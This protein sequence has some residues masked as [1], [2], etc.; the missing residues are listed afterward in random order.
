M[1]PISTR[2]G[3]Q[4]FNALVSFCLQTRYRTAAMQPRYQSSLRQDDQ[5][6]VPDV[7]LLKTT[8]PAL[9][10]THGSLER[11]QYG[12]FVKFFRQASPYIEGHRGRTFVIAIPGEVV[13][14]QDVLDSLL[15]DIALLHGLGVRLT[16]VIG[17]RMQIN[18]AIRAEGVEPRYAKGYRVTDDVA[19]KAAIAAAGAARMIVEARLS[20]APTVTMMRRHAR[21]TVSGRESPASSVSRNQQAP[22]V[23]TVS[24][25]YVAAKRKGVVGGVDYQHTGS[26][27]FVQ[28]EAVKHQLMNGNVVLL[29]NLGYSATGEPL[30]CD[31]YS[32][33][34][35]AA[36]DLNAD[37][38]IVVAPPG[39]EA[40]IAV[41]ELPAWIPLHEAETMLMSVARNA[42]LGFERSGHVTSTEGI[43]MSAKETNSGPTHEDSTKD[44]T[45]SPIDTEMGYPSSEDEAAYRKAADELDFD[46]WYEL[47]LPMPLLAACMVCKAGVKRAH[48]IDAEIDGALLLELYSTDGIGSMISSDFYEGIRSATVSDVP[49]I[50]ILLQ[51]LVERGVLVHRSREQLAE[52]VKYFTV[53]E[54]ES[55]ILACAMV[56]PL[57]SN[58]DAENVAELGAF[59]VHPEYRGGGKG[60]TLLEY[61][62]D[63]AHSS[64][65]KRLI[66][67]TTRTAEWFEQ[68]GFKA[69]GP[70]HASPMVPINRRTAIDPSRNS[71]LYYKI[72]G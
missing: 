41:S 68:R 34:V 46:S 59:C 24:G 61:L 72:V 35:R 49:R 48:L 13:D 70:A 38:L 21:S 18:Q 20:K 67:L 27:R 33:A 65:V 17:A 6:V 57:G 15:Q 22:A 36:V 51:P 40:G 10:R 39:G 53:L 31:I 23:T 7:P 8:T 11:A 69:A 50:H 1:Q 44:R 19:L 3:Y 5:S 55:E 52:D 54:R 12:L 62:E 4:S 56:R 66:L 42:S 71:Q 58:D 47:G 29:S 60:D 45:V 64:G 63:K 28:A 25:N 14:R 32:V 2:A 30:N 26:V 16:V 37:K 43:S 9:D